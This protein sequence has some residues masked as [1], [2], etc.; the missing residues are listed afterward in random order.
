MKDKN[1]GFNRLNV[2]LS[3]DEDYMISQLIN[4]Y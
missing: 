3:I 4:I 2:G 1:A